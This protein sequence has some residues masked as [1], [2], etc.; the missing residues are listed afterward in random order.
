MTNARL[1]LLFASINIVMMFLLVHKQ[2][3]ITKKQYEIQQLLE[4]KSNLAEQKKELLLQL[5]KN[6]QLSAVEKYA[7]QQLNMRPITLPEAQLAQEQSVQA[8]MPQ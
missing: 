2:N 7:T 8:V 5:H 3:K 1:F 4:Q 6:T